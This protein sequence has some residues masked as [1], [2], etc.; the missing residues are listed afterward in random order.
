MEYENKA[1]SQ[2][3]EELRL[4]RQQLAARVE[5]DMLYA[6]LFEDMPLCLW[7]EDLSGV[8]AIV[9]ALRERDVQDFPT[10]F[11]AH[12]DVLQQCVDQIKILNVNQTVLDKHGA[13]D[14]EEFLTAWN[15][16]A[17]PAIREALKHQVLFVTQP[18]PRMYDL[19]AS[20]KPPAVKRYVMPKFF[21]SSSDPDAT[22]SR[23]ILAI[24][25]MTAQVEAQQALAERNVQ[26]GLIFDYA[27][28]GISLHEEFADGAERRL[29][30]CNDRYAEMA[31]RSKEELLSI[32]NTML[33]QKE[34]EL[35]VD[36]RIYLPT[37]PNQEAYRGL[38]S[39]V[40][41]DGKENVIEYTAGRIPLDG[42]T[43][44]VG[45][46]RDITERLQSQQMMKMYSEYLETMVVE[47]AGELRAQYRQ[48]DAILSS[49]VDGIV[50]TD[51]T[52][53]IVRVN[54]VAE[55]WLT[56][57]LYPKDA[58]ELEKTITDLAQQAIAEK[59][60][61]AAV[62]LE[63]PGLDL[64][65]NAAPVEG[66]DT[67]CYTTAVVSIHDISH[68][69]VMERMKTSFVANVSHELRTPI[70][71]IK[72]CAH[73]IEQHP[74]QLDKYLPLLVIAAE[75]QA[76]LA[77]DIVILSRLDAG[78]IDLQRRPAFLNELLES[79]FGYY[80]SRARQQDISLRFEPLESDVLLN[81]DPNHVEQLFSRLLENALAY[82]PKGGAITVK[83]R[84]QA[85][86][87]RTGVEVTVTDTGIGI[88]EA[89]KPLIFERFFRGEK[90]S[91]Y[92]AS[93]T[94]LGLAIVKAVA[95]LHGGQVSVE[96]V[97]GVG[98]T[99]TVWLPA[100]SL[101]EEDGMPDGVQ[102]EG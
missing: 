25:D 96:S 54:R 45:L 98:S 2:L 34:V 89:E 74:D 83:A 71:T 55:E 51:D 80:R 92:Q 36:S 70:T 10:Y 27:Y 11:D 101:T 43:L 14:K 58:Q 85:I 18:S 23:A 1:V 49:T 22:W 86:A 35:G 16:K 73:L 95:E 91:T 15:K 87:Q 50:V 52:G 4:L 75:Q 60:R 76:Q 39:W 64:E 99:F 66:D 33:V 12:P 19:I 37:E 72:L 38:F 84:R 8:K 3:V 47:R 24:I 44:V 28:D 81:V 93:G 88:P 41:P 56:E 17:D 79:G 7:E 40:R 20:W 57:T 26:L 48:L 6:S 68:L 5:D 13:W 67:D 42:R 62:I 82:T 69:K 31:G 21:V 29:L 65:L 32:G 30:D 9:D 90:S 100:Y 53:R 61:A 78:R 94:G 77:Q 46:D 63:L 102:L 97:E 59:N